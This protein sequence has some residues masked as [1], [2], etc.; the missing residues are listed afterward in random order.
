[1][2]AAPQ[3]PI[4]F[5]TGCASSMFLSATRALLKLPSTSSNYK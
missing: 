2:E 3:L 4:T 5:V 1:M